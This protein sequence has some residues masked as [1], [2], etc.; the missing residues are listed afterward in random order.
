VPPSGIRSSIAFSAKSANTGAGQPWTL[1]RLIREK[2]SDR[3]TQKL[4]RSKPCHWNEDLRH[5]PTLIDQTSN[6]A[7]GITRF[8]RKIRISFEQAL[9]AQSSF[10]LSVVKCSAPIIIDR[11][12]N[13]KGAT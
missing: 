6:P 9:S 11:P 1:L 2:N 12:V 4:A 13:D 7:G 10:E 8:I 5:A 3:A